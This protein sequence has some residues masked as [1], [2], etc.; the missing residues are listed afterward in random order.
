MRDIITIAKFTIKEMLRRKSFIISTLIILVMI[1]V[2]CNIPNII[3]SFEDEET[4]TSGYKILIV[5]KDNIFG[6]SIKSLDVLNEVYEFSYDNKDEEEV[7]ELIKNEEI[8]ESIII[9]K[10][11]VGYD[12][13]Y[14]VKDA[15]Y[16]ETIPEEI[17]MVLYNTYQTNTMLEL[18]LTEEEVQTVYPLINTNVKQTEEE[19]HG[20]VFAMMLMSIVLFYAIYFCAYQVSSSITTE[21]TSKIIETLVTST[22]PTNIVIG[23]T[24]GIGLVGLCQLVLIIAT[25]VTSAYYFVDKEMIE[26][27]LDTSSITWELGLIT[28]AFFIL[29]YFAYAFIYA[30]TGSTVSKPEDVQ[31]ANSPVAII[32]VAGFYLA[33]FSMLNPNSSINEIACILPISS[34][35]SMPL[36]YM[37]GLASVGDVLLSL[38]LLIL[39]IIVVAFIA[40]RVYRNAILNYGSKLSFKDVINFAKQ[41]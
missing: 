37:M 19:V 13:T 39:T 36:R 9:N 40:I 29:G 30:L 26:M 21:K 33:Y 23:K 22:S 12:Y 27:V 11:D 8:D 3:E 20:D 31:S 5:D 15:M 28:I 34:P 38:G 1:V 32:A 18:G 25:A 7:E 6:E 14:I 10:T 41:K 35:F 17:N 16:V 4:S 24:F 2:G